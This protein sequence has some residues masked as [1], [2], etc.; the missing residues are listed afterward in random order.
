MTPRHVF[1]PDAVERC[2]RLG[3]VMQWIPTKQGLGFEECARCGAMGRVGL[4]SEIA[5]SCCSDQC[6]HGVA[7]VPDASIAERDHLIREAK[8]AGA[9]VREIAARWGISTNRVYQILAAGQAKG[10][11]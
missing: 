11:P 10:E 3:H 2:D 1:E 9:P 5:P 8:A 4:R 6:A 7:D